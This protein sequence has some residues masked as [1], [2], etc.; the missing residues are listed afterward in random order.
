MPGGNSCMVA[1]CNKN[2]KKAKELGE[3]LV[4]FTFPKDVALRKEWVIKCRQ[5]DKFD[6]QNKRFCSIHFKHEDF[7]DE[8]QARLMGIILVLVYYTITSHQL[9][10]K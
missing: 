6:P 2:S 7:E 1:V 3:N 4:F 8:M 5:K 10:L 9:A